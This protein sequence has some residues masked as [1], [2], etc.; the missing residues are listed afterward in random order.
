MRTGEGVGEVIGVTPDPTSFRA[1]DS[2]VECL[3]SHG[4][5]LPQV[6]GYLDGRYLL[7]FVIKSRELTSSKLLLQGNQVSKNLKILSPR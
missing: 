1:L 2:I 6:D 5:A 4:E 3:G 7:I